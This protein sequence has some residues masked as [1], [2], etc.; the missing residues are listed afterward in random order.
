LTE[1]TLL[2]EMSATALILTGF[3]LLLCILVYR[4]TRT[5]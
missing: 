5:R 3:T 1:N 2:I 4:G